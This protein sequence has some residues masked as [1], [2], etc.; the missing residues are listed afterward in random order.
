MVNDLQTPLEAISSMA[1][2]AI[3]QQSG[4]M[5]PGHELLVIASEARRATA[6]VTRLVSFAQPEQTPAEPVELN[7]LLR[8]LIQFREREWKA[9]GIHL[10]NLIKEKRPVYVLGSQG[11]F[12]QVFLNL[13][14]H[15]EQAL[16]EEMEKRITVRADVLAKRVFIEQLD[17]KLPRFVEFA[18]GIG[19]VNDVIR[20]AAD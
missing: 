17:A 20:L 11:Q 5:T 3:E 10:S 16:E 18:A 9:C 1:D 6:I 2:S 8:N 14:V 19:A 7:Q 12:E 4:S 13:L 15:A